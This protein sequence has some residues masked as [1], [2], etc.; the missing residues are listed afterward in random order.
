MAAYGIRPMDL[1]FKGLEGLGA[2]LS[3]EHGC[4][5]GR[6][7]GRLKGARIY[8][9]FPSVGATENI[10]MAA[11]LAEGQT[12]IENAAKEPEIVDL[13]NFLNILGA[14]VR[15]AGTDVIKIDGTPIAGVF[16]TNHADRIEA[17]TF[18][19]A[20]AATGEM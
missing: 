5:R 12:L 1:H 9:D 16:A 19:V 6:V 10:M 20:S 7:K 15:G 14:K 8:L 13:A 11:C 17:G 4:I 18:M 3:L 2:E